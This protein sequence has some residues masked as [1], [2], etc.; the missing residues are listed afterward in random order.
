[1]QISIFYDIYYI[2]L[3]YNTTFM[4]CIKI[5]ITQSQDSSGFVTLIRNCTCIFND[6]KHVR[7]NFPDK[8]QDSEI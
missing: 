1:L 8:K 4:L 2:T 6:V 5:D 7:N 3:H